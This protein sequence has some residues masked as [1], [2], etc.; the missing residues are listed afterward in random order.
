MNEQ[1]RQFYHE[2]RG[3]LEEWAIDTNRPILAAY[4]RVLVEVMKGEG[5]VNELEKRG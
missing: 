2:H 5:A 1:V 3:R 4:S